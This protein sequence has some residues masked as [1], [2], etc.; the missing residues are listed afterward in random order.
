MWSCPLFGQGAWGGGGIV[1]MLFGWL[2]LVGLVVLAV[3]LVQYVRRQPLQ[4]TGGTRSSLVSSTDASLE[5]ARQRYARGEI[6]REEYRQIVDD[7]RG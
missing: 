6:S 7:L 4:E 1:M 3:W 2:F 5:V